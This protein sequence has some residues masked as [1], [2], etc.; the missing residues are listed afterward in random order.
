MSVT[1]TDSPRTR[2]RLRRRKAEPGSATSGS[3]RVRSRSH[4]ADRPGVAV[5]IPAETGVGAGVIVSLRSLTTGEEL[6]LGEVSTGAE[7]DLEQAT[8][9]ARRMVGRWGMSNQIGPVSVLP[10]EDRPT[11]GCVEMGDKVL[12]ALGGA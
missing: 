12:A 8:Q 6:V 11:I 3:F 10:G 1:L 5:E 2:S 9:I 4:Y 7:N